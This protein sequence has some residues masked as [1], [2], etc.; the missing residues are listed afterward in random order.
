MSPRGEFPSVPRYRILEQIGAGGMGIVYRA[1]DVLLGRTV[2]LKLLPPEL[3][4]DPQ[5]RARLLR[6]AR[7]SSALNHPNIVTVYE[8]GTANGLDFIAMEFVAG[9]RLA[10]MIP[11][12]GMAVREALSIAI[13]VADALAKAHAAGI[14]HR[15]VKPS[16]IMVAE[17]I[18]KL[19]DFGLAKAPAAPSGDGEQT[20]TVSAKTAEGAVIGTFGYMSPEQAQGQPVDARSDIF[21][22]GAVLY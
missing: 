9:P 8:V 7:A 22:F 12:H 18:V 10:E 5:H 13:Q 16:N 1:E 4:S 2:A 11:R 15:D 17:G 6:E 3:A 19:L 20:R 14:V 21:S